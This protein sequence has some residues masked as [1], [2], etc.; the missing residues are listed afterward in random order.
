MTLQD[1]VWHWLNLAAPALALAIL[2][3][4]FSALVLRPRAPLL[5]WWAQVLANAAVGLLALLAA[6]VWLGR[7]GKMSGYAALVL[8]LAIAQWCWMRGW[9]R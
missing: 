3:P 2:L 6:L 4:A 5:P 9:R 7:D 8:A 1:I